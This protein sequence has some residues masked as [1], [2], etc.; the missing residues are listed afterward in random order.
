MHEP[1][2]DCKDLIVKTTGALSNEELQWLFL[3]T[4]QVNIELS[5]TYGVERLLKLREKEM[6][7]YFKQQEGNLYF[8][9]MILAYCPQICYI[10]HLA[11]DF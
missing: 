8:I 6:L 4:K 2:A 7:K 5:M 1:G 10:K 3:S 9:R 11:H